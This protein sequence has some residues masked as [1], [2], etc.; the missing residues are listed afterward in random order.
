MLL[1]DLFYYILY[2]YVIYLQDENEDEDE[3]TVSKAASVCLGLL[4][5]CCGD[6]IVHF[7]LPFITQNI[8]SDNWHFREAAV[9]AFGK[10][11]L[12]AVE[13]S[14][15]NVSFLSRTNFGRPRC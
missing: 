11:Q 3:W 15:F 2:Y 4:A 5:S 10:F 8:G 13:S 12:F 14:F 7:T 9:M 1:N 6:D